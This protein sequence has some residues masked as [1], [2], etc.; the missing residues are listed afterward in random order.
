MVCGVCVYVEKEKLKVPGSA[1]SDFGVVTFSS[2][3][4]LISV[5]C[6]VTG[7]EDAGTALHRPK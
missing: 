5:I 1:T 6:C 3:E 7:K 4:M 2:L